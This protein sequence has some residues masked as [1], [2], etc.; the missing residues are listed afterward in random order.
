MKLT[1]LFILLL[2][3]VGVAVVGSC[4]SP[5]TFAP[6]KGL[7]ILVDHDSIPVIFTTH[8]TLAKGD[9]VL[10]TYSIPGACTT[11]DGWVYRGPATSAIDGDIAHG[12]ERAVVTQKPQ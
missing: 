1:T 2:L 4:N 7:A 3:L 5:R 12:M 11:S 6:Q 10:L 8:D 9:V